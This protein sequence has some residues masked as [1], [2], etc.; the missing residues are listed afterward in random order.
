M[1][2]PLHSTKRLRLS[3]T[4]RSVRPLVLCP[5]CG[6]AFVLKVMHPAREE[7]LIDLQCR[8]LQHLAQRA[9]S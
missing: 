8:A 4:M 5:R 6:S 2:P 9:R 7:S 1:T 3:L